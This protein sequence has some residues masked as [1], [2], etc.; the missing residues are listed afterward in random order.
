M[1]LPNKISAL[2]KKQAISA[3]MPTAGD[4]LTAN[5]ERNDDK[6][7]PMYNGQPATIPRYLQLAR[8]IHTRIS[9]EEE[10]ELAV[11]RAAETQAARKNEIIMRAV[12]EV[13][14][15]C[16]VLRQV[17]ELNRMLDQKTVEITERLYS[18]RS[19]YT[20]EEESISVRYEAPLYQVDMHVSDHV[21]LTGCDG[22]HIHIGFNPVKFVMTDKSSTVTHY[23][24]SRQYRIEA[25]GTFHRATGDDKQPAD[26]VAEILTD[27]RLKLGFEFFEKTLLPY[28]EESTLPLTCN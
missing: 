18:S 6:I 28:F 15:F 10:K 3:N 16:A 12:Q 14:D 27:L 24:M 19:T 25:D 26:P 11:Y 17:P 1:L 9:S 2:F 21:K 4:F 13:V 8:S 22:A 20:I 5:H 23:L 7:I